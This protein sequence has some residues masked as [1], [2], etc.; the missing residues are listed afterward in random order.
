MA[1][2]QLPLF[3][4]ILGETFGAWN[5]ATKK[6]NKEKKSGVALSMR[7]STIV[8]PF[9]GWVVMYRLPSAWRSRGEKT[10]VARTGGHEWN[11][12]RRVGVRGVST[13][14]RLAPSLSISFLPWPGETNHWAR[15]P[16][17]AKTITRGQSTWFSYVPGH[18]LLFVPRPKNNIYTWDPKTLTC[19]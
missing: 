5:K 15:V 2:S 13:L 17:Y 8:P 6:K 9:L 19:L 16:L 4:V 12:S 3:S 7:P 14:S 1:K 10:G 11:P 18:R